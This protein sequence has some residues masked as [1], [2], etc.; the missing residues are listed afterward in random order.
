MA[1]LASL[2]FLTTPTSGTGSLW[3]IL[4][5]LVG[6]R[7]TPVKIAE[8]YMNAGRGAE[9]PDWQPEPTGHLYMYNTSHIVN[10]HL[11]DRR[12][13]L[14][15]NFRD[16][17]D[18]AC[19]QFWWA[20]QHPTGNLP[21]EEIAAHRAQIEANGIDAYVGR[22]DN[23]IQFRQFEALSE[24]IATDAADTLVVSYAQLCLDFDPMVVRLAAFLGITEARIPW[25]KIALERP[26]ALTQN[27]AWIGQIWT[28]SD[29]SPGR[30]RRDLNPESIAVQDD[31][32]RSLLATL[33]VLERPHLQELLMTEQERAATPPAAPAA[34]A[35]VRGD[36]VRVA[37]VHHG[38]RAF[39]ETVGGFRYAHA[40]LPRREATPPSTP[41]PILDYIASPVAK[42]WRPFYEPRLL[43]TL[44]P[45][46]AR[47]DAGVLRYVAAFLAKENSDLAAALPAAAA[48]EPAIIT[49]FDNELPARGG[50]RWYRNPH[51][52]SGARGYVLHDG[53]ISRVRKVL[54]EVFAEIFFVYTTVF[55][56]DMIGRFAPD[57]VL[58]F[59]EERF[60]GRMPEPGHSILPVIEQE[61]SQAHITPRFA[62]VW[63]A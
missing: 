27:P 15:A 5:A 47:D 37:L 31:R 56:H 55:D 51:N 54:A 48:A 20:L 7:L 17:R 45:A 26:E 50:V 25:S 42:L 43:P 21:A 2:I 38:R 16:P 19:N 32:Y 57:I 8:Q 9:L 52:A 13:R 44:P 62:T 18:L 10:R 61:E 41:R 6:D 12:L 23:R 33:R 22:V 40:V 3:R 59:E 49:V 60:F 46:G 53:G 14:V 28:G 36:F 58:C 30:Y 4:T 34:A 1:D 39:G 24:R 63:Q 35:P 11:G 29:I